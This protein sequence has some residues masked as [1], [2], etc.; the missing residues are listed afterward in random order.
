MQSKVGDKLVQGWD[1][2]M[3]DEYKTKEQLLH[4]LVEMRKRIAE[5]EASEIQR[6]QTEEALRRNE[7]LFRTSVENMLNCFGIYSAIR[8]E[9]GR[10]AA[11][12]DITERK[13]M[14]EVLRESEASYRE[15]ADS[16]TDVFFAM[17]TDLRYTYW[18]KAS[19][20]LTGISAK[21]AIG[22]SLYELFPDI[23]GT[24]VEELYLEAIRTQQPKSFVNKY[25]LRG[26]DFFFEISAY[27]S[28]R[29]L[30]VF[31]KDI[32]ERKQMEEEIRESHQLL[33]RTFASL[34]DAIFIID[35]DTVEIIDCNPAASEIFGYSRQEML[36][37]TT[38]FLHVDEAALEEFRR[39]LYPA[40]E[41]NGFLSYLDFRMKRKDGTVFPTEHSVIPL[42]DEQGK[43][44]G[45]VSVV[46]DITERK[47]AE[48]ALHRYTERLRILH[49]IDRAILAA[50]SPEEIAQTSLQY[51]RQL[52]SCT[53]VSV[54]VFDFEAHEGLLLAADFSD[55]IGFRKGTRFSIERVDASLKNY[56]VLFFFIL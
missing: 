13:R 53:R 15:L 36:G 31:V 40:I 1:N 18:N 16:I 2:E 47:Q 29:G 20:N 37:R 12:R 56:C 17:D 54:M 33:E 42:E 3:R 45:W 43:R 11:W 38:A 41:K 22:K 39:H 35:A 4:E 55:N 51:I 34:R 23:K 6:K 44:T 26:K 48:E 52:V 30:S 28:K 9:S 50:Q 5:L 8:D 19:E 21:D 24:K 49:E 25:Q 27:P 7:E 14:E 10:I 46:R 32:T